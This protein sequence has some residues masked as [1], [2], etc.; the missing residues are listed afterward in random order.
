MSYYPL[1]SYCQVCSMRI[2]PGGDQWCRECRE[3]DD[4]YLAA[5][6]YSEAP[7]D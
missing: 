5:H 3:K 6:P 4:E 2:P 1:A 7:R